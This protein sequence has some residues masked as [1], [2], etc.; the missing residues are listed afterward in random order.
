M[1]KTLAVG[2]ALG[3]TVVGFALL[4][5]GLRACH[6]AVAVVQLA[7]TLLISMVRS[8]LRSSRLAEREVCLADWL[9][10]MQGTNWTGSPCT[11]GISTLQDAS[12]SGRFPLP[13]FPGLIVRDDQSS[14]YPVW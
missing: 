14:V 10:L 8:W 6:S 4:F 13:D 9:E 12:E 2:V 5:L 7:L 3:Y 11:S 1:P